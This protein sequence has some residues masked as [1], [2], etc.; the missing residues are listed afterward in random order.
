MLGKHALFED[1][2]IRMRSR[3]NVQLTN[4]AMAIPVALL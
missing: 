4:L 2:E 1:I 3:H